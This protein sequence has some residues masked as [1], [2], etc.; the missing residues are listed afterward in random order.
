MGPRWHAGEDPPDKKTGAIP[1]SPGD[2]LVFAMLFSRFGIFSCL[3]G[4]PIWGFTNCF[5]SSLC[6]SA[7]SCCYPSSLGRV[8]RWPVLRF[9]GVFGNDPADMKRN[10]SVFAVCVSSFVCEGSVV[11]PSDRFC[12]R[13][14]LI[15]RLPLIG[16]CSEGRA[17]S[18]SRAIGIAYSC[19]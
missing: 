16:V 8:F 17:F 5:Y 13:V 19:F 15:S 4:F 11:S 18:R 2:A 3:V 14:F 7:F 12:L 1:T 6:P 9:L 10:S